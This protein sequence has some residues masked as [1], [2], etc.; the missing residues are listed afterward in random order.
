MQIDNTV[1]IDSYRHRIYETIVPMRN[2]IFNN[3]T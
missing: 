3:G 1:L 2:A